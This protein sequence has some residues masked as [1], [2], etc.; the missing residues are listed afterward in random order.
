MYSNVKCD[1]ML[2]S[3]HQQAD[4][5][6]IDQKHMKDIKVKSFRK[7]CFTENSFCGKISQSI[8]RIQVS[9]MHVVF[10]LT[11]NSRLVWKHE[12]L[13]VVTGGVEVKAQ[14]LV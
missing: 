14:H 6:Q 7:D 8:I 13:S 1:Y 10:F 11:H 4:V 9:G 5:N 12:V 3:V 2:N